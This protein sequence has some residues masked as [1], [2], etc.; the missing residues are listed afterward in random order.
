MLSASGRTDML[1]WLAVNATNLTAGVA[2]LL[3]SLSVGGTGCTGSKNASCRVDPAAAHCS[4]SDGGVDSTGADAG[5][6][7]NPIGGATNCPLDQRYCC[8]T[9]DVFPFHCSSQYTSPTS[10][11]ECEEQPIGGMASA[12]DSQTGSGC[13]AAE[14]I[15]CITPLPD[16]GL[17]HYCTDHRYQGPGWVC[18]Q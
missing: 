7:C 5:V 13:P 12:C 15:C 14:P 9:P 8:G 2:L 10:S 18:S 6:S 1:T 3:A 16:Q 11:F 4:H 17:D